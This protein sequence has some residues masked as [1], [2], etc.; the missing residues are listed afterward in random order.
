MVTH[1]ALFTAWETGK[2]PADHEVLLSSS[3]LR[4]AEIYAPEG[5]G[6]V[7]QPGKRA[8]VSDV[9]NT[10]HF[11]TPL[12]ELPID[13]ITRAEEQEYLQFR[14]E[15]LRLWRQFFDPVG[16]RFALDKER[17]RIDTYI[18]PLLQSGEYS[19]LRE[20]AR[21][22][23]AKL[24]LS[25]I[26]A[27]TLAQISVHVAPEIRKQMEQLLQAK[28]GVGEWAMLRIDDSAVFRKLAEVWVQR[29]FNPHARRGLDE[30]TLLT[31]LPLS[32]GVHIRDPKLLTD[33]RNRLQGMIFGKAETKQLKPYHGVTITAI[34]I[35]VV[36]RMTLYHAVI[37]DAWY[38]SLSEEAL[39]SQIDRSVAR[40]KEKEAKRE[41]EP[42]NGS[43]YIAP[44]ALDKARDALHLVLEWETHRRAILNNPIWYPLFHSG[45]VT[46][47]MPEKEKHAAARQFYG[48]VPVGPDDTAY[49]YD[50]KTGEV[51]NARHG[52]QG[53][54]QR[55][56][57]LAEGSPLARLL[58]EIRTIRADLRFR[59]DGVHTVL[60]IDRQPGK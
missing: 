31:Q 13:K 45:L 17:V 55:H 8:A 10:L 46:P 40:N 26:S 49:R 25:Q 54:P 16:M 36:D 57:G 38:L 12:I 29:E 44:A 4:P 14:T 6:V 53:R 30:W 60:T 35:S 52:S 1:A 42:F 27:T 32:A 28:S 43:L 33:A 59:E 20:F 11:P 50:A 21:G 58:R 34:N 15:Y 9:Y 39:K 56:V 5:K 48:F 18:L 2:L 22:G 7:W 51:V 47:D 24:D 23:T 19:F 41:S 37:D 3:A